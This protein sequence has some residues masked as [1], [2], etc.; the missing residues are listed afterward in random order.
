[1]KLSDVK[2]SALNRFRPAA[3]IDRDGTINYDTNY[4]N[5]PDQ[6]KL[7][8]GAA[9]GIQL[10]NQNNIL[11][12]AASNQSGVARGYLTLKT[13]ELIHRKLVRLLPVSGW[14]WRRKKIWG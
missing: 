8:P 4:V 14:P 5:R 12:V 13:L 10:L 9:A 3:F 2:K 1:M 11:T 7:L 6:L